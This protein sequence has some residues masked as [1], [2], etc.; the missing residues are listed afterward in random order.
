MDIKV[1]DSEWNGLGRDEQERVESIISG[2]FK[3][4]RIVPDAATAPSGVQARALKLKNPFC[5]PACDVLEASASAACLT[6]SNPIAIAACLAAA[7]AAGDYCRS[8]C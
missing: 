5:K 6:L 1:N 3:E 4:A 2:F 7:K 8:R